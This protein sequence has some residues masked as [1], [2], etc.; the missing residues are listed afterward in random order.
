MV[1][2]HPNHGAFIINESV[3]GISWVIGAATWAGVGFR[4]IPSGGT[5]H[6]GHDLL[7]KRVI[8]QLFRVHHLAVHDAALGQGF[9][10]GDGVD[11]VKTVLFFLGIEPIFLD[12]L[13]DPALH[14]GPGQ[15][16][17][18]GAFRAYCKR[19]FAVAAVKLMGQ[20]CGGVFFTGVVLHVADNGVLAFA[21]AVPVLDG[22]VNVI[23]RKWAQQLMEL[24]IGLVDN[25]TMKALPE[26]PGCRNRGE[27][28]PYCQ[29]LKQR[30]E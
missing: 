28:A 29:T 21:L 14:L 16:R 4:L 18:I 30:G 27:A 13:G 12:K 25:F 9:P 5:F 24:G 15:H 10:N 20:P 1:K 19:S 26:T 22:S 11:V 23:V 7:D 8:V 17:S 3:Y 2:N 6:V